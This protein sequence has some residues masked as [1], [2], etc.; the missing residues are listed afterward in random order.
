[1]MKPISIIVAVAE[2]N[3]IGKDNQLLCHLPEDLKMFKRVTEG[4]KVIMGKNTYYSLPRRPLPARVNVVLTD[5]P[6][7]GPET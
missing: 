3:A 1:M 6:V 5:Q 4:Y 7:A 2:N